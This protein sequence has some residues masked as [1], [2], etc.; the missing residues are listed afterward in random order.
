MI[1]HLNGP[2]SIIQGILD[3]DFMKPNQPTA[4]HQNLASVWRRMLGA[5][6]DA[7]IVGTVTF[8]VAWACLQY[9]GAQTLALIASDDGYSRAYFYLVSI[10]IDF[11]YSVILQSGKK[12]STWGQR[13]VGIKLATVDGQVVGVSRVISRYLLSVVSTIFFKLGYIIA[14]FTRNKQ[15]FHDGGAGTIVINKE[16]VDYGRP[17]VASQQEQIVVPAPGRITQP[18]PTLTSLA[19]QTLSRNERDIPVDDEHFWEIASHELRSS[20]RREGLWA[21]CYANANGDEARAKVDYL[22]H[23]VVQLMVKEPNPTNQVKSNN[24]RH[25]KQCGN[26]T[27]APTALCNQCVWDNLNQ[28]TTLR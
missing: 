7:C 12:Q 22:K 17:L 13:I 20:Q 16:K 23:R 6:F 3:S 14:L 8:P 27:S 4:D 18:I 21:K 19:S 25:C 15:T 9:E 5:F 2:F 26:V 10:P 28:T 11:I 1:F 24:A